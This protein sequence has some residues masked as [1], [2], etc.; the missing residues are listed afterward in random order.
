MPYVL[1]NTREVVAQLQKLATMA[2]R[3]TLPTFRRG[4]RESVAARAKAADS[5]LTYR[6]EHGRLVQEWPA[7]GRIQ[8]LAE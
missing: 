7:S 1:K 5:S 8:V 6:D 4:F 3:V 2:E